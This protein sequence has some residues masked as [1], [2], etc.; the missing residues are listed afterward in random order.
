MLRF[1]ADSELRML[2]LRLR[3][4]L[5]VEA[6]FR[7]LALDR[8]ELIEAM[9]G[10]H[11]AYHELDR[12]F[13]H[14]L[15]YSNAYAA[16]SYWEGKG[17][18]Y[19]PPFP[20]LGLASDGGQ[21]FLSCGGGGATAAKEVP[22]V[23]QAHRYDETTGQMSTIASLDTAKSVVVALSYAPALE[24]WLGCVGRGCKVLQLS[25]EKNTLTEVCEWETEETGK[26][27]STNVARCSP[28]GHLVATG[29]TDGIV[30]IFEAAKLQSS[31]VLKHSCAKNDEVL[32][33][34]FSPD[35]KVLA[36][37]DRT[38]LCRL[39]DPSTGEETKSIDFKHAG[40]AVA[41]RAIRYLPPQEGQ[42]HFLCAMSA[43]RGPACLAI[44]N[45]DGNVV[46]DVKVHDKP[47]TAIAVDKTGQT[48]CV[49]LVTGGKRL[50]SLPN[51]RCLKKAENVHDLPAPC[52][53][54]V[55]STAVSGSGD[56]S[57][58]LLSCKK[59]PGGG[60]TSCLYLLLLVAVMVAACFLIMRIGMKGA[61]LMDSPGEL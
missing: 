43:P 21:I 39:W 20:V 24:L 60:G 54:F 28:N 27:P 15:L 8:E 23:V 3:S 10:H 2:W 57:I 61:V 44:Y 4:D 36:S 6:Q 12:N 17:G 38:G 1:Q 59:S 16:V 35:N 19:Y 26:P 58:N 40:T 33:L 13:G 30:R 49:N 34:E 56:R 29:G 9:A 31:P 42:Q 32:D 55:D 48:V 53:V 37:C 45:A 47:L 25:V 11:S 22:N 41:I 52:A 14:A 50:Y 5:A 18:T 51:M 46:K 7:F